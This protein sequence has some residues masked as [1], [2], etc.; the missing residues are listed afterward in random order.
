MQMALTTIG[1]H[2]P[3]RMTAAVREFPNSLNPFCT[4]EMKFHDEG[5]ERFELCVYLAP[6]QAAY[7]QRIA[8]AINEAV[9]ADTVP[10]AA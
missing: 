1:V 2:R 3:T 10:Q 9:S 7:A 4:I 6:E 5:D 8:A